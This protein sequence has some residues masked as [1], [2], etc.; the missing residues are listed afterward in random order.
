[1]LLSLRGPVV[2][3]RSSLL[4]VSILLLFSCLFVV[5]SVHTICMRPK[6]ACLA[7]TLKIYKSVSNQE[8]LEGRS[9]TT[10]VSS[11]VEY[12]YLFSII[13]LKELIILRQILGNVHRFRNYFFSQ[14]S[15][16]HYYYFLNLSNHP[17]R[18]HLGNYT[19]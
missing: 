12:I 13:Y 9:S 16:D 8:N 14:S 6:N 2:V 3:E 11:C 19:P 18:Y 1:M 17:K 5:I 10:F 4:A 7:S 15:H